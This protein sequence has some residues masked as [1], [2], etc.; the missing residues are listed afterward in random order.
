MAA[1]TRDEF[2]L[3]FF[4]LNGSYHWKVTTTGDL[5]VLVEGIEAFASP[6]EALSNFELV[7]RAMLGL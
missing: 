2:E 5:K 6:S 3:E 4:E 1:D 7:Q